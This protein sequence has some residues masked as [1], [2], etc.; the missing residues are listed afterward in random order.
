M[1]LVTNRYIKSQ[2]RFKQMVIK[3]FLEVTILIKF[4]KKKKLIAI[5]LL[6]FDKQLLLI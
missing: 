5:K 1:I 6:N 4:L 2:K 3:V